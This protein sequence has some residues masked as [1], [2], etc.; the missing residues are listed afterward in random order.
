MRRAN[1][2][3][4]SSN[5]LQLPATC[6]RIFP[7]F[8][9]VSLS[10]NIGGIPIKREIPPQ[11]NERKS[12]ERSLGAMAKVLLADTPRMEDGAIVRERCIGFEKRYK[13]FL[14]SPPSPHSVL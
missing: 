8:A 10:C 5:F 9:Y 4:E 14:L 11:A 1:R 3:G 7:D 13:F 12:L 6:Y 2:L